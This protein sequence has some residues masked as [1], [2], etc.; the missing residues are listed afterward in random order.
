MTVSAKR[1]RPTIDALGTQRTRRQGQFAGGGRLTGVEHRHHVTCRRSE[2]L[3]TWRTTE[4]QITAVL[5][6]T[7]HA[8]RLRICG[9]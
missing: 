9:E 8:D 4:R 5:P 1:Q 6:A 2:D 7:K 3:C